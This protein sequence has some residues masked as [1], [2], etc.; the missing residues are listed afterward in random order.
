MA[1]KHQS[2]L[3]KLN[4]DA[5]HRKALFRNQLKELIK[6][7]YLTTTV[8]KAKIIK[9]LF[10]KLVTKAKQGT[11]SSRRNVIATLGNP[12]S[13][14][15]LVDTITPA[16][17]D[18]TSGFTTI[19]KTEVRRGDATALAILKLVVPMPETVKPVKEDKKAAKKEK[20]VKKAK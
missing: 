8:T 14:N 7:G 19:Q 20:S 15:R 3:P 2:R 17:A 6:N 1:V 13:G 16:L 9:R 12:A 5:N 10:D 4:R 11:L 18:R